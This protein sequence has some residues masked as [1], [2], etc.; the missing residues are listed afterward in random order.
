VGTREVFSFATLHV[1]FIHNR[2]DI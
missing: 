2:N 1:T